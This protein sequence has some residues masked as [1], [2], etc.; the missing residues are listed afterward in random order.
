M[1]ELKPLKLMEGDT[2]YQQGDHADELYMIQTGNV[3]L[4]V[5]VVDFLITEAHSHS[6]PVI[7]SRGEESDDEN[8]NADLSDLIFP[9]IK[10]MEGSY[11][12]D[13]DIFANGKRFIRDS[14]AI[15]NH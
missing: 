10:Y 2:L 5:D 13:V 4:N 15:A 1:P 14:T 12:G 11:F 7:S 8:T 6:V 3:K 9:F